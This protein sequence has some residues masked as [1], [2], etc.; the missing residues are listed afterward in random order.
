MSPKY[1][2][3]IFKIAKD[4]S[5]ENV[6]KL[7]Q[8]TSEDILKVVREKDF[9]AL[10]NF[11]V[12]FLHNLPANICPHDSLWNEDNYPAVLEK[13]VTKNNNAEA[14]V[15][16]GALLF[17]KE[18]NFDSRLKGAEYIFIADDKK[19]PVAI[20]LLRFAFYLRGKSRLQ[21]SDE[22]TKKMGARDIVEAAKF[23]LP[24]AYEKAGVLLLDGEWIKCDEHEGFKWLALAKVYVKEVRKKEIDDLQDKYVKTWGSEALKEGAK[25]ARDFK[26]ALRS[27]KVIPPV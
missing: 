10:N 15:F 12:R 1:N 6:K 11:I 19:Y 21:S 25:R 13:L 5:F 8:A 7:A 23:G 14:A 2:P 27:Y 18:E 4:N 20:G 16:L 9:R 26:P 22:K 17:A 24:E 3:E